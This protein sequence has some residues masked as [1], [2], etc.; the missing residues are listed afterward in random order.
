[1]LL[2]KIDDDIVRESDVASCSTKIFN[3]V[4]AA[5]VPLKSSPV[6]TVEG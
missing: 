2:F 5:F 1:M 6:E 3:T 4:V